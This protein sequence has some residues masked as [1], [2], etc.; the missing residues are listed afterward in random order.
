MSK[1]RER[2]RQHL[3]VYAL[4]SVRCAVCWFRK[5]RPGRRMELHH[6][7][8]RRGLDCHHHRNLILLCRDCHEGYHSGG[9]RSL[10]LGQILQ[11]KHD[12][13]GEVDIPFLAKLMGK[14]GLRQDPMPLPEWALKER[15]VNAKK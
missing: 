13:D 5:Y 6:I 14:V 9:Q 12:E 3:E 10:E 11:A 15:E 2:L 8:G 4:Q 7:V 1:K